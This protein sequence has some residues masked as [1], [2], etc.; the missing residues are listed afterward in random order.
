MDSAPGSRAALGLPPSAAFAAPPPSPAARPP[1]PAET[2]IDESTGLARQ[3]LYTRGRWTQEQYRWVHRYYTGTQ[4]AGTVL[5]PAASTTMSRYQAVSTSAASRA[6]TPAGAVSQRAQRQPNPAFNLS[7]SLAA[8]PLGSFADMNTPA[9]RIAAG[10]TAMLA[11]L[12]LLRTLAPRPQRSVAGGSRSTVG[13]SSDN[14]SNSS[15]DGSASELEFESAVD[16]QQGLGPVAVL[17]V[18][19]VAELASDR[20]RRRTTVASEEE[21]RALVAAAQ[22][23]INQAKQ[24]MAAAMQAQ[25]ASRLQELEAAKAEAAS[26]SP[27]AFV[28]QQT[29]G[30]KDGK[31]LLAAAQTRI[32]MAREAMAAAREAQ[33]ELQALAADQ[34]VAPEALAAAAAE[35]TLAERAA[36]ELDAAATKAGLLSQQSSVTAAAERP[37]EQ[38]AARTSMPGANAGS[39]YDMAP[40]QMWAEE[41]STAGEAQQQHQQGQDSAGSEDANGSS[42][43]AAA[44]SPSIP[45]FVESWGIDGAFAAARGTDQQG[46]VRSSVLEPLRGSPGAAQSAA[47]TAAAA[48]ATPAVRSVLDPLEGAGA[49]RAGAVQPGVD[50]GTVFA[51]AGKALAPLLPGGVGQSVALGRVPGAGTQLA[52]E[53]PRVTR[54]T[55]VIPAQAA[56]TASSYVEQPN[57]GGSSDGG[58]PEGWGEAWSLLGNLLLAPV[59]P[60]AAD[61]EQQQ[62][63]FGPG[64]LSLRLWKTAKSAEVAGGPGDAG[65]ARKYDML[66]S[67]LKDALRQPGVRGEERYNPVRGLLRLAPPRGPQRYDFAASLLR[68]MTADLS[69]AGDP[70][71]EARAKRFDMVWDLVRGMRAAAEAGAAAKDKYD[72]VWQL[73]EEA[74]V[75]QEW[76]VHRYDPLQEVSQWGPGEDWDKPAS[77]DPLP[78][79][80]AA[81]QAGPQPGKY[82]P[83]VGLLALSFSEPTG[84]RSKYD[85][86]AE[87]LGAMS[88][89]EAAAC[90]ARTAGAFGS[91]TAK[92]DPWGYLVYWA[93]STPSEP[94]PA[95]AAAGALDW[96]KFDPL[97][98][99]DWLRSLAPVPRG[100]PP[101]PFDPLPDLLRVEAPTVQSKYDMA[102]DLFEGSWWPAMAMDS[103]DPMEVSRPA[104]AYNLG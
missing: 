64:G 20:P 77:Y 97:G 33:Q 67:L 34:G 76:G 61:L 6:D 95:S 85:M 31:G 25:Q 74:Q 56:A 71:F 103:S 2:V 26:Q 68:G 101:A 49:D 73:L 30:G 19:D 52:L 43:K 18:E 13:G 72:P 10:L 55:Q 102:Q 38:Q 22:A 86:L 75:E 80:F 104:L 48:A 29:S 24:A 47:P 42:A 51:S 57:G 5:Q 88:E 27:A 93:A 81:I 82:D 69:A 8:S 14:S 54:Q 15:S 45:N 65:I 79:L 63:G 99:G 90:A 41:P 35:A 91:S 40:V 7:S 59:A 60:L 37:E 53:T 12:L 36:A 87:V 17:A 21:R 39:I 62:A 100:A 46:P 1:P 84:R 9:A 83:M 11:A 58:S 32:D 44:A 70:E 3:W 92:L 4:P 78:D 96:G 94:S 98:D 23:R 16:E 28:G 89:H 66:L 50:L